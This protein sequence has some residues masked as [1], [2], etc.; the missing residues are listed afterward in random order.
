M[1]RKIQFQDSYNGFLSS[2]YCITINTEVEANEIFFSSVENNLSMLNDVPG[3]HETVYEV[4]V[5]REIPEIKNCMVKLER[6]DLALLDRFQR[7]RLPEQVRNFNKYL[8]S[9]KI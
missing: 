3:N 7:N 2:Q 9:L 8:K 4:E 5:R 1:E 6:Y